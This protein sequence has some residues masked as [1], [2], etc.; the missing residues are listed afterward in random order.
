MQRS[1]RKPQ[2]EEHEHEHEQETARV[3]E[4]FLPPNGRKHVF[5]RVT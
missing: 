3:L 2:E 1:S 5:R 4:G